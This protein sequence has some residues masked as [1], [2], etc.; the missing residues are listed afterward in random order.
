[1]KNPACMKIEKLT[2]EYS[3]STQEYIKADKAL[4]DFTGG[5]YKKLVTQRAW[6]RAKANNAKQALDEH[7]E[8]HGC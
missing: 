7:V 1:M 8:D 3:A 6:A 2:Q 4:D 5:N